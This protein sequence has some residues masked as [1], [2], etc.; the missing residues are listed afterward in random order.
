MASS[1]KKKKPN[2]ILFH[3]AVI[4]SFALIGSGILL[5]FIATPQES[6]LYIF[7]TAIE[8]L[9]ETP[10]KNT[11]T[12][13]GE[14]ISIK[15]NINLEIES[16]K[17]QESLL[18]EDQ[19]IKN[20]ITNLN[21]TTSNLQ[22]IHDKDNKKML[23]KVA[24][25]KAENK[26]LDLKLLVENSTEY[27]FIDGQIGNYVNNGNSTYFEN[28]NS[29][30]TSKDNV[31]YI[32]E[33][34]SKSLKKNISNDEFRTIK[35]KI[36]INGKPRNLNKTTIEFD[37]TRLIQLF[38]NVLEDLKSDERSKNILIGYDNDFMKTKIS[39]NKIYLKKDEKLS[40]YMYK[41]FFGKV[42]KYE[43]IKK[44]G[45]N[46]FRYT[47]EP[48]TNLIYIVENNIVKKK[49]Q[50]SLDKNKTEIIIYD[51][52]DTELGKLTY[53]SSDD[54]K[55]LTYLMK[56]NNEITDVSFE[57]KITDLKKKKSYTEVI[58]LKLK[59]YTETEN[60]LNLKVN[61][62]N[63]VSSDTKIEED[64]SNAIFASTLEEE[65][66][67]LIDKRINETYEILKGE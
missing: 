51:S 27:F 55:T 9:K 18:P 52:Q 23:V 45:E 48:S 14:N 31:I 22:F 44:E 4:I 34:V 13:I 32:L 46:E 12:G 20:L 30:T 11:Y 61:L 66:E 38:N 58:D 41:D 53:T 67:V 62:N 43:I 59:Y 7:D 57:S 35:E 65:K 10:T 5:S 15:S 19:T 3:I 63:Q 54:K 24:S 28:I 16:Q 2:K 26:I 8:K 60:I 49:L 36:D 47:Y 17:Y 50:L 1:K 6:M 39:K 37:N 42:E 40:V 25:T 64:T 29:E 33:Q 56:E 21:Q